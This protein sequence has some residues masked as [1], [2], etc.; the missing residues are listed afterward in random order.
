[1]GLQR[2]PQFTQQV[3][4]P[5]S[6]RS[7]APTTNTGFTFSKCQK[8]ATIFIQKCRLGTLLGTIITTLL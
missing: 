2:D 6:M 4:K 5:E 1:M 3:Q 8:E 7:L